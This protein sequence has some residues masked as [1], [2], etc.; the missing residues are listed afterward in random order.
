MIEKRKY[1]R[2]LELQA[3]EQEQARRLEDQKEH[4]EIRKEKRE[5]DKQRRAAAQHAIKD[6]VAAK[7]DAL[8]LEDLNKIKAQN[9]FADR[10][11]GIVN[12]E[13]VY[14]FDPSGAMGPSRTVTHSSKFNNKLSDVTE[15]MPISGALSVMMA[16]I[17]GSRRGS[18]VDSDKFSQSDLNF[19]VSVEVTNQTVQLFTLWSSGTKLPV[20]SS[21]LAKRFQMSENTAS[22]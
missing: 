18:F 20:R 16:K 6:A 17:G 22:Y 3:R 19:Y 14:S 21:C 9:Q 1:R 11:D 13:Q 7:R 5:E 10:F 8:T 2:Q 4:A 12:R 15:D